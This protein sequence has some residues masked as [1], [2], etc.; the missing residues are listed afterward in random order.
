MPSL[1]SINKEAGT[2]FRRWKEVTAVVKDAT[3]IE[4]GLFGVILEAKPTP[5]CQEAKT[6][7]PVL[8][9]QEKPRSQTAARDAYALD[10][11]PTPMP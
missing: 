9:A 5:E 4:K 8:E 11:K 3:P 2:N 10:A 1:K 7:I 6:G